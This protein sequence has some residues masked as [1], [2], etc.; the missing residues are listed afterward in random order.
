MALV[1]AKKGGK[2]ICLR[3]EATIFT[4]TSG[5]FLTLL[6]TDKPAYKPGDKVR[7]R[8]LV[9]DHETKPYK[10]TS[11]SVNIINGKGQVSTTFTETRKSDFSLYENTYTLPNE[12]G[13][14]KVE[15]SV[16]SSKRKTRK[17]FLVKDFT[18]PPFQVYVETLPRV[19]F[20][21]YQPKLA[22]KVYAK[23][24][25]DTMVKGTADIL[26]KVYLAN[27]PTEVL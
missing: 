9:L 8:V 24:P 26:A 1:V 7:F 10:Y 17:T 25:F 19:S 16:D 11:I 2:N 20:E 14:W 12:P 6:Q 21:G 27:N 3:N 4:T 23:Y 22:M 15:V 5:D 13:E 18:P